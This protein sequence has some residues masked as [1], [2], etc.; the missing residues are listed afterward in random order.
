MAA[1]FGVAPLAARPTLASAIASAV[2][3]ATAAAQ[4]TVRL[5]LRP[6]AGDTLRMR[7]DQKI[8]LVAMTPLPTGGG[9]T[10]RTTT[11]LVLSRVIVEH[12][13]PAGATVVATTD[14]VDFESNSYELPFS[15]E[16]VRRLQGSRVRLRVAPDGSASVVESAATVHADV[17][18]FLAHM[19]ATLPTDQVSVGSTW[20]RE[21]AVP[22]NGNG[23]AAGAGAMRA[24]FRLDSL[25]PAGATAYLSVSGTLDRAAVKRAELRGGWVGVVGGRN[26][27]LSIDKV[28]GGS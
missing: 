28:S 4:Q 22:A 19:P 23:T 15:P 27:H 20:S 5:Q 25:S 7:L 1:R 16:A 18:S 8:E 14:S 10:T 21:M 3:P 2:A 17:R 13:D 12:T 11:L 26:G 9:S 24:T 6:H